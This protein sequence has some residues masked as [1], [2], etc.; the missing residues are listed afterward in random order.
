MKQS[1][2]L[3]CAPQ[4]YQKCQLIANLRLDQPVL[5]WRTSYQPRSRTLAAN[6]NPARIA[7]EISAEVVDRLQAID[8][9]Q[10]AKVRITARTGKRRWKEAQNAKS[11][12]CGELGPQSLACSADRYWRTTTIIFPLMARLEPSSPGAEADPAVKLPPC[13][14]SM[15]ISYL[16][17]RAR[18]RLLD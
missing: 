7:T 16:D 8:Y 2:S 4:S 12:S 3:G 17:L 13:I 10:H 11:I 6:Y 15:S 14:L 18:F 5:A 1:L 9:V